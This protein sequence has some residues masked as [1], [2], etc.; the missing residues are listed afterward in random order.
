MVRGAGL[1]FMNDSTLSFSLP[2]RRYQW[3]RTTARVPPDIEIV[4]H[5]WATSQKHAIANLS[6]RLCETTKT[7]YPTRS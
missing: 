2:R 5:I 3:R 1:A 6:R 4:A 7:T